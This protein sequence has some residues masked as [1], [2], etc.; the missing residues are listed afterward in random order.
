MR[1]AY[2]RD[3]PAPD[4]SFLRLDTVGRGGALLR[5]RNVIDAGTE[6]ALEICLA[7]AVIEVR[8]RAVY[9]RLS[10]ESFEVGVEFLAFGPYGEE[11][12][13]QL[14]ADGHE[15]LGAIGY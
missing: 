12:L 13:E 7:G 1:P 2:W 8:A 3:S 9:C 14:L 6:M 4:C 5:C 11:L 10:G 15:P